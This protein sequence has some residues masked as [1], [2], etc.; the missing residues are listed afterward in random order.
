MLST[1]NNTE[2]VDTGK[3]DKNGDAIRKPQCV[4][5]YNQGMGRVDI[6][7]QMSATYRSVRKYIKWCIFIYL[8]WQ[9]STLSSYTKSWGES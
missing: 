4:V 6:S 5:T 1:M 8:I 2:M 3:R 9:C 7:D